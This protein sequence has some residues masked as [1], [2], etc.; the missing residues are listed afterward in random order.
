MSFFYPSL[1]VKKILPFNDP[2]M[3]TSG[4]TV[5]WQNLSII[6][7]VQDLLIENLA[8]NTAC[9]TRSSFCYNHSLDK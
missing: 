3:E 9:T 2:P 6:H 8:G 4:V 7:Y 1:T 5:A